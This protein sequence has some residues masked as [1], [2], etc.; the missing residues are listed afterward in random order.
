[1]ISTDPN[2]ERNYCRRPFSLVQAGAGH[3]LGEPARKIPLSK[4]MVKTLLKAL[5]L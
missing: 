3:Q 4:F 2:V 5:A 1:M